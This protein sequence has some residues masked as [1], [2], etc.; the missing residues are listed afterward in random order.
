[1]EAPQRSR[2]ERTVLPLLGVFEREGV[3]A[4]VSRAGGGGP[5]SLHRSPH[6]ALSYSPRPPTDFGGAIER[7]LKCVLSLIRRTACGK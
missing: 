4:E 2:V 6:S 5:G 7:C 3:R 1:M